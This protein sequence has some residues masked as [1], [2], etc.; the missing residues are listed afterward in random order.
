LISLPSASAGWR[1]SCR[2]VGT[3]RICL[4]PPPVCLIWPVFLMQKGGLSAAAQ[5][6]DCGYFDSGKIS[7]RNPEV[8]FGQ[9][10]YY[11]QSFIFITAFITLSLH[12]PSSPPFITIS[13]SSSLHHHIT[14]FITRSTPSS[15]PSLPVRRTSQHGFPQDQSTIKNFTI[16]SSNHR[17]YTNGISNHEESL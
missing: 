6:G 1:F 15:S 5:V 12:H 16:K 13:P 9:F 17:H 10:N 7:I 2:A 11:I 3:L 8:C 14:L 4:D